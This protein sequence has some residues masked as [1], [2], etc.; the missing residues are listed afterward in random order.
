M[1][2][3][4]V[5]SAVGACDPQAGSKLQYLT[6]LLV[7]DVVAIDAVSLGLYGSPA[8]QG[9][10]KHVFLTHAH[11]D[12]VGSLPI[13]LENVSDDSANCPVIHAPQVVLDVIHT[14]VLNDRLFPDFVRL[15]LDGPPLVRLEPLTPGT[16][17]H[18]AGLSVTA[19]IRSR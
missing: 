4:L 5:P 19:L 17:V 9:R 14:D 12:H 15:S 3:M 10:V 11:M 6:T 2:V 13:F 7:N 1:K 18:V 16:P 8:D